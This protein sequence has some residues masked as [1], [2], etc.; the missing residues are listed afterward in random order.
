MIKAG[1]PKDNGD[2]PDIHNKIISRMF[3]PVFG[4]ST[5][6][7]AKRELFDFGHSAK[8]IPVCSDLRPF[9]TTVRECVVTGAWSGGSWPL[10]AMTE[11]G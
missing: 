4:S 6:D 2:L 1:C 8:R 3:D 10:P 7:A 11:G 5:G 9:W